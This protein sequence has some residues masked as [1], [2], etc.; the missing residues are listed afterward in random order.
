MFLRLIGYLF[1]IGTVFLLALAAGAAWY[2]S[3]L[4][5]DVPDYDSLAKYEP[6]EMT[7][8][9]SADGELIAEFA[10]ERRLYLPIESIPERVKQA[11]VAAEDKNFYS[12]SGLDYVGIGRAVLTDI[13]YLGSAR[14]LV[15]TSTITQQVA[16]DF[17]LTPDQN[18]NRK[19]KEA[20]L[21]IRI[22]HAL[23]KQKI[24]ELYL[25]D[26]FLGL[27]SYGVASA[28]LTYFDKS[29]HELTLAEVAFLAA[30]PKG[31]N[32]YNPFK[33]PTYVDRARQP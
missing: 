1:G 23:N 19:V 18:F 9:H 11:F 14:R 7:R 29:V 24:L 27:G 20:I 10:H 2:V 33:G 4:A 28:A 5:K 17:F 16:R 26:I 32:N 13:A 22:E 3:G 6:P 15:G 31:P 30:L 8:V 25:N 21:A 12:H